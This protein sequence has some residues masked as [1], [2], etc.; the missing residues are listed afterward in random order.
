VRASTIRW[1]TWRV[2]DVTGWAGA[3]SGG[4]DAGTKKQEG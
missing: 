1:W 4:L 2:C 3:G